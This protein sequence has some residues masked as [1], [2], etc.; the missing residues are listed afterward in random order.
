MESQLQQFDARMKDIEAKLE[1]LQ[2]PQTT[3]GPTNLSGNSE[4]S[5]E[6][7]TKLV[8]SGADI[9]IVD[10]N[11]ET[12]LIAAAF[13]NN[14]TAIKTLIEL[15]ADVNFTARKDLCTPLHLTVYNGNTL[16]TSLLLEKGADFHLKDAVGRTPLCVAAR[17][18]PEGIADYTVI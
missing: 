3:A 11:G 12:P 18:R 16:A 6:I 5:K 14:T 2:D 8:K 4:V 9:N 17:Y 7:L 1:K 13:N 10:K 15:G